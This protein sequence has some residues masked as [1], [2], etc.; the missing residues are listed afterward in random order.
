MADEKDDSQ[1]ARDERAR[2]L[3]QQI[4]DIESGKPAP[5]GHKKSL[6]EQIDEAERKQE[7][8]S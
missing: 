1:A 2:R 3:R 8:D 4:A 7:K 5:P 6:R